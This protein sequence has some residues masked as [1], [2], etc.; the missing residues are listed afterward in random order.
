MGIFD[1]LFRSKKLKIIDPDYGD[2][3]SIHSKGAQVDWLV[4]QEFLGSQIDV[5]LKGNTNGIFDSQKCAIK[6]V[7]SNEAQI[8]TEAQKSLQEQ[9]NNADKIFISID[10]HFDI[11]SIFIV[12]EGFELTFQEKE[13]PYYF[14]NVL[15]INNKAQGVSIDS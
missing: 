14:F 7:F 8:A 12:E 11:R 15:F 4:K 9:F 1:K 6:N 3:E 2:I 10:H 13:S 5:F